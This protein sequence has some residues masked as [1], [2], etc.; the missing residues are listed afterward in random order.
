MQEIH[1]PRPLENAT[2]EEIGQQRLEA[3]HLANKG[4]TAIALLYFDQIAREFMHR[5]RENE[6]TL[7]ITISPEEHS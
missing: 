2:L 6:H 1:E 7:H 3:C 4:E 5:L